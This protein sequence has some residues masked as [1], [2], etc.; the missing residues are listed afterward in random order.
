[1]DTSKLKNVIL[2]VLRDYS[3]LL[4]SVFIGLVAVVFLVLA[5][6]VGGKL[7]KK[8][9]TESISTGK[10]IQSLINSAVASDQWKIE[11]DYQQ[12][13][14][15]DANEISFLAS[16]SS[17]RQLLSYK[18]FP[19]PKDVSTLI[20]E[21]FGRRFR[22]QVE[23]LIKHINGR[24]CPTKAELDRSLQSTALSSSVSRVT[25]SP[26]SSVHSSGDDVKDSIIDELCQQKALSA[27]VYA[28]PADL[29]GY[30]F[31]SNFEYVGRDEAVEDCWF[32]QLGYW[33]YED[34][35]D[36][37]KALN[38]RSNSVFTSPVKR[39]LSISFAESD[40]ARRGVRKTVSADRPNYVLSSEDGLVNRPLTGRVSDEDIDVVHFKI[41]GLVSAKAVLLF[42]KQL[43][44][45][46]EHKFRGFFGEQEEAIFSH[47]Q[48]T[49]LE[50]NIESLD[51]KDPDY[52]KNHG[53]YCY[54]EDAVVKLDLVCEYIFNKKSYDEIKPKSVK[55]EE[56]E[57]EKSA[58]RRP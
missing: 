31:W 58:K 23:E 17:K 46:K 52:E 41:E 40:V 24:D 10:Q 20:F 54:G 11:Q 57:E 28:N 48:I 25:R 53:Y 15:A 19:E 35:F 13:Y 2:R 1:M 12:A 22:E 32:W 45:E 14:E 42:M 47:N 8:M 44:S 30:K 51:P 39:L 9:E 33:I 27:S 49:I 43:C 16:Q 37:I 55:G 6:L 38:Y 50:S 21:E 4:V 3:S 34:V 18:I 26:S 56:P 7:K 5:P 29:S 36:T